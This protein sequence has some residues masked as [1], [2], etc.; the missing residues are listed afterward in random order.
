MTKIQVHR[1][2]T[3]CRSV[4][5]SRHFY[6]PFGLLDPKDEGPTFLRN[7]GNDSRHKMASCP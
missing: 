7:V 2:V 5:G 6:G 3:A 4:S 1:D